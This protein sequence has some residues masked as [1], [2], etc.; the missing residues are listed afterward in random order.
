MNNET[1]ILALVIFQFILIFSVPILI[2]IEVRKNNHW[3]YTVYKNEYKA[4][5]GTRNMS[6]TDLEDRESVGGALVISAIWF[7]FLL[8]GSGLV[9]C[10][11]T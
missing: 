9:I 6:D 1:I 4:C 3:D 8:I 7:A 2:V 10:L 11:L 5:M